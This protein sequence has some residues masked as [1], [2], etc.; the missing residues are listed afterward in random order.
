MTDNVPSWKFLLKFPRNCRKMCFSV[1]ELKD[2]VVLVP[3]KW[4]VKDKYGNYNCFYPLKIGAKKLNDMVCKKV[5]PLEN[6]EKYE[7]IKYLKTTGKINKKFK[8]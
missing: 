7:I 8:N 1:V 6:W 4:I 5:D 3:K 2:G